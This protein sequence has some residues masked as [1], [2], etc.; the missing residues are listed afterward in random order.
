MKKYLVCL[1]SFLFL[2][3]SYNELKR[4][5]YEDLSVMSE[6]RTYNNIQNKYELIFDDEVL[7]LSNFKLK[8]ANFSNNSSNIREIYLNYPNNLKDYFKD[9]KYIS[10]TGNDLN[11]LIKIIKERYEEVL[12]K[13]NV[14]ERGYTNNNISINKV[15][16]ESNIQ[17]VDKFKIKYPNVKIMTK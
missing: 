5:E 6:I 14:Y 11:E 17:I 3:Y 8:M 7:N 13:N 1:L 9:I 2:F 10:V 15:I 16:L 4:V 12:I